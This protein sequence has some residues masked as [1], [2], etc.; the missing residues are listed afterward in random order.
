MKSLR[1]IINSK[2]FNYYAAITFSLSL[3]VLVVF[4]R[5]AYTNSLV[6]GFLLWNL[7]LAVVP[8]IITEYI[9]FKNITLQKPLTWLLLSLWIVFLPNTPYMITDLFHLRLKT[10]FF[11]WYDTLLIISF[12][13][14]GIMLYFL[15]LNKVQSLIEQKFNRFLGW[16]IIV[17]VNFLSAFGMYLGRY[18]RWNSWDILIKPFELIHDIAHRFIFPFNHP[19]TWA[20]TLLYSFFLSAGYFLLSNL[21]LKKNQLTC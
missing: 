5:I 4:A 8:F 10:P 1:P 17:L 7:F 18:L 21:P 9:E 2:Y 13:W 16:A 11:I 15:S 6:Y 3:S 20:M 12:A 14:N 19:R